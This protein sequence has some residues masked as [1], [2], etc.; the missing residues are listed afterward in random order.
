MYEIGNEEHWNEDNLQQTRANLERAKSSLYKGLFGYTIDHRF[1]L[2]MK[3]QNRVRIMNI[4]MFVKR[5]GI[6]NLI[7]QYPKSI[8][9]FVP[10]YLL[11]E[12]LRVWARLRGELGSEELRVS[13]QSVVS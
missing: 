9:S 7:F 8:P 11:F 3:I 1:M 12:H 6:E 5:N 4:E 2:M 13:I 10:C